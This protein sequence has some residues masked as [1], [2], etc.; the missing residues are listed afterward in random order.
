M[1]RDQQKREKIV[2][3]LF[4]SVCLVFS[5]VAFGQTQISFDP[6]QETIREQNR[7]D[8]LSYMSARK[9]TEALRRHA[10]LNNKKREKRGEQISPKPLNQVAPETLPD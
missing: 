6:I 5:F 8:T 10:I 1:H 2:K 7:H 3:N 4:V 9:K